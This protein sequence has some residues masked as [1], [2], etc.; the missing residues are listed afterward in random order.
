MGIIPGHQPNTVC[1]WVNISRWRQISIPARTQRRRR[2]RHQLAPDRTRVRFK[3]H[4]EVGYFH[5]TLHTSPKAARS[6]SKARS[7]SSLPAREPSHHQCSASTGSPDCRRWQKNSSP[8]PVLRL[9]LCLHLD[10][11]WSQCAYVSAWLQMSVVFN[12]S[13]PL[14]VQ[15]GHVYE[16]AVDVPVA[17]TDMTR[18]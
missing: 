10:H 8:P 17:C 11:T 14:I 12:L 5:P 1:A 18:E 13:I 15:V 3:L 6:I 9:Y 16:N 2:T 4:L 7:C